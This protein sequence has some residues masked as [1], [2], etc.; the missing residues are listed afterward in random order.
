MATVGM[1]LGIPTQKKNDMLTEISK[2]LQVR[3]KIIEKCN[4]IQLKFIMIHISL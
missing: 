3:Y 2:N 4:Q 1:H